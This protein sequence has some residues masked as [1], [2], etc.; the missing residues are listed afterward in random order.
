MLDIAHQ[1]SITVPI[2]PVLRSLVQVQ[3]GEALS[4]QNFLA[5]FQVLSSFYRAPEVIQRITR[6]AIEDAAADQVRY[7]ELHFSPLSLG[8]MQNFPPKEVVAWVCEAAQVAA[9]AYPI[10]VSLILTIDRN[11][12]LKSAG[13]LL[14]LAA[15]FHHK[16]VGGIELSGYEG[17]NSNRPFRT[18]FREAHQG[19]LGTTVLAGAWGS[20]DNIFE[21]LVELEA[22]RISQGV[23]VLED[24]YVVALAL[25]RGT[26]F[27]MCLTGNYHNG[28]VASLNAHP[29]ARMKNAGINVTIHTD[30]PSISQTTLG[31]EYRLVCQVLGLTRNELKECISA[32]AAAAFLPDATRRELVQHLTIELDVLEET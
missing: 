4:F 18:I 11:N 16:G 8:S 28:V 29:L 13:E 17:R 2:E 30:E 31:D 27:E 23:R 7:L 19:G 24:P 10:Q 6:E 1:Y 32:A 12:D 20:A 25:E 15:E 26:P 5:K 14:A 22:D 9:A 3:N 21:A